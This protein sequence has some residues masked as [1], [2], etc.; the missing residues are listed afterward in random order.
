MFHKVLIA[1]RGE[2]AL[3]IHRACVELGIKTVIVHSEADKDSLPVRLA[4]QAVCIGPGPTT[5]SYL[6]IPN[7]VS[8][9]M[10][11]GADA[12]HPGYGLLSEN[13][14]FAE[15]CADHGLK[16]IGP[17]ARAIGQMG[18]KIQ[19]LTLMKRLGVPTIPG[20]DGPIDGGQDPVKIARELGFPV[21][22]KAAAGGGGRGM[23]VV[24]NPRRLL[25][26]LAM[27][28]QEAIAAFGNGEVYLEKYLE[29][30][31]HIEIQILADQHGRAIHLGERDCSI[32]RR[33]Q[34]LLEESPSPALTPRLRT[35]MGDAA[36]KVVKAL[37]YEGVGT[38]E[39]LLDRH[40]NFYFM[41]MNTRIQVEHPV[42]E[43]VTRT[44][45]VARQIAIAAG[46]PLDLRQEDIRWEGH[47]IECRINAEDPA[48]DFRPSPGTI[49]AYMP[50]G[51]PGVRVDSHCYPGYTIPP[52][53]DSM[54]AKLIVWAPDR[55]R[56]IARMQRA[57]GEFAI[58]GVR[59]TIPIHQRIL[60]NAFFQKG[61]AYTN[62]LHRRIL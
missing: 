41:E 18:D 54:I 11:T 52:Y 37:G 19:A 26:E 34:K 62:F 13:A 57:L 22:V 47:S 39:F 43:F 23:R 55:S 7:I 61:E 12:V 53:Y 9:A 28:Q 3:R 40:G 33:H 58:T 10:L 1:N 31:R 46:E 6:N 20:S 48:R 24:H 38:M 15:I 35:R 25:D 30:P 32:Q 29:E 27:A 51:G 8:A 45:L 56:A 5:Q 21:I 17:S 36:L 44:D 4:D 59:T 60:D 14:R 2:I 50:P 42:T 49:D 16:F